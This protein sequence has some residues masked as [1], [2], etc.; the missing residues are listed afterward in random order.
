VDAL[1]TRLVLTLEGQETVL[2][3]PTGPEWFGSASWI[4]G[5]LVRTQP[6]FVI[7]GTLSPGEYQM[8]VG[9]GPQ[10]SPASTLQL[11]LGTLTVLDREHRFDLPNTGE[12]A[13]VDWQEGIRL[14]RVDVPAEVTAGDT[15]TVTLVWRADRPTGSNWKVFVHLVDAEGM[16][17]GQGDSYPAQ[18]SALTPTWKRGEVVIDHHHIELSRDLAPGDYGLRIGFYNEATDERLPLAP[19]VDR[20]VWPKPVVVKQP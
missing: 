16:V 19:D 4:P 8:A 12:P 15:M 13:S 6:S 3:Q 11:P 5:R 9:V 14:A 20:Y 10:N 7:P 1:D 17:K 2:T 18:G